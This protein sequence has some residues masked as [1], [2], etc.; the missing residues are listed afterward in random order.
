MKRIIFFDD[1]RKEDVKEV[2]GKNANL[3][4]LIHIGIP[5]PEGFA[6]TASTYGEFLKET[7]LEE[8]LSS[9][10]SSIGNLNDVDELE[11]VSSQIRQAIID[12][13]MP[14][15]IEDD[16]SRAYLKLSEM[17]GK[18]AIRVAVRSSATAEDLS[19]ASFAGQQETFLNV[20]GIPSLI[21]AVK[22]CWA[23]LFTGR[24]VFYRAT[25]GFGQLK[26]LMSVGVQ[27]MIDAKASGIMFTVNPVNGKNEI[28]IESSWGL[29]EYVVGGKVRPD[30]FEVDKASLNIIKR[31]IANKSIEL[32]FDS[33]TKLNVEK[34]VPKDMSSVPSLTDGEIKQLSTYA[35]RIE[36]HYGKPMDMEFAVSDKVY[37][38]QARPVTAVGNVTVTQTLSSKPI[39][40]GL[41]ASPGE[42]SGIVK[43]LFDPLKDADK[44]KSGDVL[45]TTMT[46]PDWVPIMKE[47]SAIVTE[48]G[49]M[50]C[51][52]A[53]VARELGVP[54]VVGAKGATKV[55]KDGE[56]VTVDASEGLVYEGIK[57]KQTVGKPRA[58]V[59]CYQPT[60]TKVYMNLGEPD[61]IKKYKDLPF[62]GIG[63]MRI[64]FIIS[65]MIGKHPLYAIK[66]GQENDFIATLSDAIS[67]V[68]TAIYPRPVIVRF[69]DFKTNEYRKLL[70]GTAYE[71]VERDPMLGWRG[72]SRYISKRYEPAFRL[73][74]KAIKNCR[75]N[76][77]K[78]VWVMFPFVRTA[79]ELNKALRILEGEGLERNRDFK[80]FAMAEVPSVILG[81]EKFS[82]MVDGF[83][84]G[85]NDLTQLILGVSRDSAELSKLGYFD[86][87]D[88][89]VKD[90]IRMLI[91]KS[92]SKGKTVSICGQAPSVYPDFTRFLINSGIDSISVN[93]DVVAKTRYIV[94]SE[95]RRVLL[96]AARK[97]V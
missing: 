81:A 31:A 25:K 41:P 76:G 22:R 36:K 75:E 80:V 16:I 42:A 48:K 37:I 79:W 58:E 24:A 32:T 70:G 65:E 20:S 50:T 49:G 26:V 34:N 93:P 11:R 39:L 63:L 56:T 77:L 97:S 35:L 88:D 17:F 62:D 40:R 30:R 74:C 68:A 86:E 91:K 85:S 87:R 15:P 64:E 69:S 96:D 55:L 78:N 10:V 38:L 90:A 23:S 9:K 51:H 89:A 4:E 54:A 52:A 29:G 72:V 66:L 59:L 44:F 94:A 27:K 28:V 83:S 6:I 47:A 43:V 46:D 45:V 18:K 84:I 19:T 71:P 67:S 7:K 73:E 92:H 33:S 95:E 61:L 57:E 8:F 1:I 13:S 21:E 82:D 5:V 60:G 2:G 3:G 12:A 14:K 53:I